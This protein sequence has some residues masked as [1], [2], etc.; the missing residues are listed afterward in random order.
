MICRWRSRRIKIGI[1]CFG[2]LNI[3]V[4]WQMFLEKMTQY[5]SRWKPVDVVE[6]E[7]LVVA[8]RPTHFNPVYFSRQFRELL[9]A[10]SDPARVYP[11][12]PNHEAV[13]ASMRKIEQN[14]KQVFASF[15]KTEHGHRLNEWE[16][17]SVS[18]SGTPLKVT[19]TT[20]TGRGS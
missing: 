11:G 1:D 20:P 4:S 12:V 16:L 13:A 5:L 14:F 6:I 19:A 8:Y 9:R 7:P 18:I 2:L 15:E 17:C 10:D 3:A